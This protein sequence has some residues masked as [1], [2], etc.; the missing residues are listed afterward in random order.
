MRTCFQCPNPTCSPSLPSLTQSPHS[1]PPPFDQLAWAGASFA[2][3]ETITSRIRSLKTTTEKKNRNQLESN[4]VAS[5]R[6][7]EQRAA[8]SNLTPKWPKQL[9]A[10][11][12]NSTQLVAHSRLLQ[13]CVAHCTLHTGHK[14]QAREQ[15][16]ESL[17]LC[18]LYL[19][20]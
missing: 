7:A 3:Y 1:M 8:N 17:T 18:I 2:F 9:L 20:V 16:A 13:R 12:A 6:G 14:P 19:Q 4:R 10:K 5:R 15:W 11:L